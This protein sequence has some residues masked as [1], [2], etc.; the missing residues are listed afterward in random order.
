MLARR[1]IPTFS[2]GFKTFSVSTNINREKRVERRLLVYSQGSRAKVSE[3]LWLK[4]LWD[5]L[6]KLEFELFLALPETL[7]SEMKFAAMRA[8][9]QIGKR[10]VREKLLTCPILE[11]SEKPSR[12]RYQGFKRLNVDIQRIERSL[13]KTKKFSG[14]I[15]SA[16]AK[17]SKSQRGSSFLD[18]LAIIED[19]YTDKSFNWYTYL[20]VGEIDFSLEKF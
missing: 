15:R 6:S 9:L 12:V 7:N 3:Y 14:W 11:E 5:E 8:I 13:P 16:S 2:G 10:E 4:F 19:D 18:P 17:G 20:T 1:R